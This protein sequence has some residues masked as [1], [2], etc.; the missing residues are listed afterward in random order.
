LDAVV[1]LR[2]LSQMVDI[3]SPTLHSYLKTLEALDLVEQ[4]PESQNKYRRTALSPADV[5]DAA[6]QAVLVDSRLRWSVAY[7]FRVLSCLKRGGGELSISKV[8]QI[9]G[10]SN[11]T[12]HRYLATLV[13]IGCAEQN[14]FTRLYRLAGTV[15]SASEER[16]TDSS[17]FSSSLLRGLAV[18]SCLE[19]STQPTLSLEALCNGSGLNSTSTTHHYLATL[20]ELEL[21]AKGTG[22]IKTGYRLTTK[23]RAVTPRTH[24]SCVEFHRVSRSFMRGISV[25]SCFLADGNPARGIDEIH[26]Q[27]GLLSTAVHRYVITLVAEGYLVQDLTTRKYQLNHKNK[28]RW[29]K[30]LKRGMG[31]A[32]AAQAQ[33]LAVA[34]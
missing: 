1:G 9:L 27:T 7:G 17:R 21:A 2:D 8:S 25:L 15:S 6:C 33:P 28:A 31:A 29:L 10:I 30:S 32:C 12:T 16:E 18:L 13:R 11:S 14:A 5:A 26:R 19:R 4:V 24:R 22:S 20:V 34:A 3:A 23:S